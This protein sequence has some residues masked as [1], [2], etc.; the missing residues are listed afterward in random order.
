MIYYDLC[1]HKVDRFT[2][3][4][5]SFTEKTKKMKRLCIKTYEYAINV[6]NDSVYSFTG[7][8]NE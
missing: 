4:S 3:L 7:K 5:I 1:L 6:H 2:V 8:S